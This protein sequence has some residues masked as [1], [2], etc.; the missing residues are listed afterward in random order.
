MNK[1]KITTSEAGVEAVQ[2]HDRSEKAHED[3]AEPKKDAPTISRKYQQ[4][5]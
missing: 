4:T 1:E 5:C 2:G 3:P